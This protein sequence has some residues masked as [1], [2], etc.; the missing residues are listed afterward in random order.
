ME[1]VN[2]NNAGGMGGADG[3]GGVSRVGNAGHT[4][5]TVKTENTEGKVILALVDGMRPDSISKCGSDFADAFLKK[6]LYYAEAQTVM[7]SVT[8]PCHMSLFHSVV[9]ERHGVTTNTYVPPVR[10]IDGLIEQLNKFD[11]KSAIFYNWEE[12]RDLWRPGNV[13]HS[14]YM[15]GDISAGVHYDD[16]ALTDLALAYLQKSSP[17]FLFLYLGATDIAGHDFGWMS[18]KY[19][20]AVKTAW[21]C[22]ERVYGAAPKD[23]TLIV[24]ADHGGHGRGHGENIPEDMTI[25]IALHISP[26]TPAAKSAKGASSVKGANSAN[27]IDIAPTVTKLLGVPPVKEW[28]GKS[29]IL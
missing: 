7:P 16:S 21:N 23:C 14:C 1:T 13:V 6:S 17:S 2:A 12:L 27:I 15:T 5:N 26:E 18:E 11:K 20:Q 4:D 24:T 9:P 3:M 19:L 28:E 10:P 8:L 29:L 22:I 25:P